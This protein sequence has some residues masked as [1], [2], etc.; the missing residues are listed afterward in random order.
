MNYKDNWTK[1]SYLKQLDKIDF[2][3][4]PRNLRREKERS[5]NSF[6]EKVSENDGDWFDCVSKEWRE[7]LYYLWINWKMINKSDNIVK[8]LNQKKSEIHIDTQ[9]LR[10]KKIDKLLS[11][12]GY[13]F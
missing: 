1:N 7:T 11:D 12:D 4:S 3:K 2:E 8:F 6:F 13:K 9:L 10:D 5:M